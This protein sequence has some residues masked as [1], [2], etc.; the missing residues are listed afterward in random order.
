M[1]F[2]VNL[3]SFAFLSIA[4]SGCVTTGA[5]SD[6]LGKAT[7]SVKSA[8]FG[9]KP[10]ENADSD[11]ISVMNPSKQEMVLFKKYGLTTVG[12]FKSA[13]L[14]MKESGY[15]DVAGKPSNYMSV[16][17]YLEDRE[18]AKQQAGMTA[19]MVLQARQEEARKVA[20]RK[21]MTI[22]QI[23][24]KDELGLFDFCK[25][26]LIIAH[27]VMRDQGPKL[28]VNPADRAVIK[29][30]TEHLDRNSTMFTLA[31]V[32]GQID[33]SEKEKKTRQSQS[34]KNTQE[35]IQLARTRIN[36]DP[37]KI[38]MPGRAKEDV[39]FCLDQ[40]SVAQKL[41]REGGF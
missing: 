36:N 35:G 41:L 1:K 24:P 29:K 19:T 13:V 11:P 31:G 30:V 17:T 21:K 6:S 8:V 39:K 22:Q 26:Y 15:F 27:A 18:T 3:I 10:K 23:A 40:S 9:Q 34:Y 25:G 28:R 12:H 32:V 4:L 14:E 7:D 5:I 2:F 38:I 33:L 16:F 37:M 20:A